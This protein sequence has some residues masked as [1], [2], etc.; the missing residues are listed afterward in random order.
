MRNPFMARYL[1][2]RAVKKVAKKS[3]LSALAGKGQFTYQ[4][5]SEMDQHQ[6]LVTLAKVA[7]ALNERGITW[8]VGASL[9]LTIKG[10][11]DHFNDVDLMV[12]EEDAE[13][14][15]AILL[16]FGQLKPRIPNDKHR[17]KCFMEFTVDGVDFDVIAGFTIVADDKEYCFTFD[18]T[19]V[20]ET[21][22]ICGAEIPLQSVAA[23]K[24]YYAL[25][26]RTNKVAM[27]EGWNRQG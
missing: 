12:A 2:I 7:N 27:I 10:I 17:S 16:S 8:G 26:G 13:R 14:A 3:L 5:V 20:A 18:K 9:L 19:D 24:T 22:V 21:V 25:M 1:R 23:W 15:K 6:K 11:A 4:G